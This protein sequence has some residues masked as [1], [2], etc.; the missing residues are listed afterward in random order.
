MPF[1]F[2]GIAAVVLYL[3]YKGTANVKAAGSLLYDEWFGPK[4]YWKWAGALM[5]IGAIGYLGDEGEEVATMLLVLVIVT[6]ILA[7]SSGFTTLIKGL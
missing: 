1:I 4:P 7:Q 5:I 6:I 3:E 2:I